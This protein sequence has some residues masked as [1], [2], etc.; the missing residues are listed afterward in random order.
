MVRAE[1]GK[2]LADKLGSCGANSPILHDG[3]VYYVHGTATAI[4]L[5]ESV[6]EA[7]EAPG[8]VEGRRPRAAATGSR[9]R[10]STTDCS[11]RPATRAF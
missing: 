4:R 2:L 7:G 1:D 10:W 3:I 6:D 5:P 8:L 9:R 11:T